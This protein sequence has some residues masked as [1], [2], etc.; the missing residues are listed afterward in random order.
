MPHQETWVLVANSSQAK[1]FRLTQFPKIEPIQDFAHPES[2]LHDQDLIS[3][4]PGRNFDRMGTGRHSYESK[5][6]PKSLEIDK[7]GKILAEHLNLAHEN[8]DFSRLYLLANPSF[9]GVLRQELNPR[10]QNAIVSEIAKDMTEHPKSD[11]E[12]QIEA[13]LI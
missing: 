11:I 12:H 1:L 5:H 9:L 13:A 3:D 8:G 10:L 7:F 6:D 2:R 4:K